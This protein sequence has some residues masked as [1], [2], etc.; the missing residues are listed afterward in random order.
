MIFLAKKCFNIYF[1][2]KTLILT[3]SPI[4]LILLFYMQLL[5]ICQITWTFLLESFL[6]YK[7]FLAIYLMII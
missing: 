5:T 2:I 4:K 6:I 3:L 7:K 1:T